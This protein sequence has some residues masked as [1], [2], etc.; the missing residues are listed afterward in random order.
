LQLA[1]VAELVDAADS[2]SAASNG[3]G[4]QVSPPAI[5]IFR[6]K[7][8]PIPQPF[9][10]SETGRLEAVFMHRPGIEVESVTPDSAKEQLYNDIIP[11]KAVQDEYAQLWAFMNRVADVYEIGDLFALAAADQ[12][13]RSLIVEQILS[14]L[15]MDGSK[16]EELS[17]R[18][19]ALT[20]QEFGTAVIHGLPKQASSFADHLD[21]RLYDLPPLPNL[22]FMRDAAMAFR[23]TVLISGMAHPVR[24]NEAVIQQAVWQGLSGDEILVYS[25]LRHQSAWPDNDIRLEGGDFLVADR[26]MLIIGI[27]ERTS[28][29][30]IDVAVRSLVNRYE[31][32][33]DVIAVNLPRKRATIHLDMVFT[34]LDP[35]MALIYE[36]MITGPHRLT[37]THGRF[38]PG[39]EP[40]FTDYHG[41]NEALKS[42]G[43]SVATV[44]CGGDDIH[45][46]QREQW[47]AGTNVFA[48]GPGKILT[49]DSNS[50]TIDALNRAGY[51]VVSV[52]E[53]EPWDRLADS[54]ELIAVTV[55]GIELAR[56]GGGIRC[57]TMPVVRRPISGA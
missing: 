53:D 30:A 17:E 15:D 27:S 24:R 22:Y 32:P 28:A 44:N 43:R 18:L 47:F 42:L 21:P 33:L 3:V 16:I 49:Y 52:S 25:G 9:L 14:G 4:V 6:M 35:E 8:P 26:D 56:G 13:R 38:E 54:S 45:Q 36:P 11:L 2:K 10:Q 41:L 57:M 19:H 46:Q 39:V 29:Q 12:R 40:R 1:G 34:Y 23:D 5:R 20:P 48:F 50:A 55:P 31:E 37:C 7:R 51:R